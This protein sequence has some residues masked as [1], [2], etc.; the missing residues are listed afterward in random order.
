MRLFSVKVCG[1][2][3]ALLIVAGA[4]MPVNQP[5]EAFAEERPAVVHNS[6]KGGMSIYPSPEYIYFVPDRYITVTVE[7]RTDFQ[8][9]VGR[10]ETFLRGGCV[11][12]HG[13][14]NINLSI[15]KIIANE[16]LLFFNLRN[17]TCQHRYICAADVDDFSTI[18]LV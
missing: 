13:S 8:P 12:T 11:G 16:V 5:I 6:K 2:I 7:T 17:D 18:R 1:L 14:N 15:T 10:T 4:I 3:S 9:T